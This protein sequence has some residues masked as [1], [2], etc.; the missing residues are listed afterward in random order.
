[1]R[2][3]CSMLRKDDKFLQNSGSEKAGEAERIWEDNIRMGLENRV[4]MY[5]FN[6]I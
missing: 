4:L 6:L 5:K 2:D 3:I 1:M